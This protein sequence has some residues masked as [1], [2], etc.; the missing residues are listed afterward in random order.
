MK[1][2]HNQS[3]YQARQALERYEQNERER[4]KRKARRAEVEH[5]SLEETQDK[6]EE[7]K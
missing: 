6:R 7:N 1:R 2:G 5:P 3:E 4:K